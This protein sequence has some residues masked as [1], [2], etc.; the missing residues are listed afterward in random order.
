MVALSACVTMTYSTI[1]AN[2]RSN[3]CK[4]VKMEPVSQPSTKGTEEIRTD[5][6]APGFWQPI[7]RALM[8][9]RVFYP[10]TLGY[11]AQSR[12]AIMKT[13]EGK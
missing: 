1:T 9:V 11:R 8:D 2:L 13:K 7:Q 6:V 12:A 5:I 10:F 4:D 3:V